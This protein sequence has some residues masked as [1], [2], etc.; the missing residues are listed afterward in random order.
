VC[1]IFM[2]YDFL[3]GM[4]IPQCLDD[5]ARLL[6][7]IVSTQI[8]DGHTEYT[9]AGRRLYGAVGEE[10]S[11][12]QVS[13]RYTDF[14]L[15]QSALHDSGIPLNLPKKKMVGNLDR[16]F[17]IK[18]QKELQEFL[19]G[20]LEHPELANV[21]ATKKFLDP[22]SYTINFQ[23]MAVQHVSMVFRSNSR[24]E[25]Q[26]PLPEIGS[27][28]RSVFFFVKDKEEPKV[29]K[30][31][32]WTDFGPFRCLEDKAVASAVKSI[33]QIEHPHIE[34]P[35]VMVSTESGI[36]TITR[37]QKGGS[38]RDVLHGANPAYNYLRK[39]G[40]PKK[41]QALQLNDIR[42]FGWQ[43]LKGL[44][45]LQDRG[46]SHGNLHIGNILIRDGSAV[47]S[48]PTGFLLG[49]QSRHR[50]QAL[51]LKGI[52]SLASLDAYCFG[53]ILYEMTFGKPLLSPTLEAMP[54]G[55]P[56]LVKTLLQSLL[57]SIATKSELPSISSLLSSSLF[58]LDLPQPQ[59]K[60]KLSSSTK[61]AK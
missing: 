33:S 35:D 31:L 61:V 30:L 55:C 44:E 51:G 25:I 17:I 16:E 24:F 52:T 43:I 8:V 37:F 47:L 56:D 26:K 3:P 59:V 54:P 53:H 46:L 12:W 22:N 39:Y 21:M 42:Q 58:A 1:L 48:C 19:D 15:L 5:Q 36:L 6:C 32:N 49:V 2:I 60:L 11:T 27:R 7:S 38:L 45:T 18:R 40:S 9:I 28:I 4:P 20:V 34:R 14:A 13:R 57:S 29:Q 23:E 41:N 50:T 10:S